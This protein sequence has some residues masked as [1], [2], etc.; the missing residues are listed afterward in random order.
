MPSHTQSRGLPTSQWFRRNR[1]WIGIF[2]FL[3]VAGFV[4]SLS[5]GDFWFQV[6][7][8][9]KDRNQ[10]RQMVNLFHERMNAGHF[11]ELYDDAYPAFRHDVS[12]QEWLRHMKETREGYGLYRLRRSQAFDVIVGPPVQ[13]R[14]TYESTF[15]QGEA[16]ETFSFA[17]DGD[18]LRLLEYGV[19][20]RSV[21]SQRHATSF[22]VGET[23]VLHE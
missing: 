1:K 14:V 23:S 10:A 17:R 21:S 15:E 2:P 9:D 8:L 6:G 22:L 16:R 20:G 5:G 7:H 4:L 11:E 3:F 19:W 18:K 13:V 12:R